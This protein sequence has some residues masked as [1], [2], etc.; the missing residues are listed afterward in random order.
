MPVH[1][2]S[3]TSLNLIAS[4]PAASKPITML[5]LWRFRPTA[6]YA[7]SHAHLSPSP[8]TGEEATLRYRAAI[9]RVI[10]EGCSVKFMATPLGNVAA[11]E[12][13]EKWDAVVLVEYPNLKA[14]RDMVEC[15]E[16]VEVS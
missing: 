16:Y 14:F 5:N 4:T 13:E 11:P 15:R 6:L 1:P 12:D 3:P 9:T 7:P 10:P 2:I 8:C